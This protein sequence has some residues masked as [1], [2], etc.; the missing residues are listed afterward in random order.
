MFSDSAQESVLTGELP[1]PGGFRGQAF[2]FLKGC[3]IQ[4]KGSF[5][6]ESLVHTVQEKR[7]S[8]D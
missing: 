8:E 6:T 3:C 7:I 2:F 1:D 5:Q 4:T